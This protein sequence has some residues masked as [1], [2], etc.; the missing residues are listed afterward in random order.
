[1][2][3]TDLEPG[4]QILLCRCFM[5]SGWE[6]RDLSAPHWR[7]YWNDRPG[8]SV[9]LDGKS[10]RLTPARFLVIPPETHFSAGQRRPVRHFY[11]HFLADPPFDRARPGVYS[12]A[13]KP[14]L[15]ADVNE[16]AREVERDGA[17]GP[18]VS[19]LCRSLV[20]RALSHVPESALHAAP[21]DERVLS[22]VRAVTAAPSAPLSNGQMAERAGM[23]TNAFV[24]LFKNATGSTPQGWQIARRIARSC[25]LLAGTAESIEQV[26]AEVG[27][28]DRYHFSR[29]FKKL[30]GTGPAE[31]RKRSQLERTGI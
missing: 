10:T 16:I 25:L 23:S 26:A 11:V 19:L 20:A 9:V 6:F 3:F 29:V 7:I 13:A 4:V 12:F 24:R 8:A 17:T 22:V 14:L 27:F 28:C 30:R 21:M 5:L 15:V 18:R 31:Y 2:S 1:M